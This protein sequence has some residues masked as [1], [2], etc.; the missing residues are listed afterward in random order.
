MSEPLPVDAWE[1]IMGRAHLFALGLV[2]GACGPLERGDHIAIP[3]DDALAPGAGCEEGLYYRWDSHAWEWVVVGD[4]CA[5]ECVGGDLSCPD[6]A[7]TSCLYGDAYY[8]LGAEFPAVDGCNTCSCEDDGVV[9]CT[10]MECLVPPPG[11]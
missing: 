8:L 7:C 9:V 2:L 4:P 1:L 5:C 11:S 3:R 10:M 6:V